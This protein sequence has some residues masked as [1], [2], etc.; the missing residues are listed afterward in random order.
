MFQPRTAP[1]H[2]LQRV[3]FG[4]A[5]LPTAA[6]VAAARDPIFDTVYAVRFNPPNGRFNKSVDVFPSHLQ[7][8]KSRFWSCRHS[9]RLWLQMGHCKEFSSG[10]GMLAMRVIVPAQPTM[11]LHQ[12]T[13]PGVTPRPIVPAVLGFISSISVTYPTFEEIPCNTCLRVNCCNC[14]PTHV[15]LPTHDSSLI[16]HVNEHVPTM[17]TQHRFGSY[18]K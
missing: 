4:K 7:Y 16:N 2:G 18:N 1:H 6:S 9:Q 3:Q 5:A 11:A 10:T 14:T 15:P 12:L 8:L 13:L 17:S